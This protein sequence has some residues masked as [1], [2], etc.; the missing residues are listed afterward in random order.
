MSG[1]IPL[2]VDSDGDDSD[3][4]D[5]GPRG[6]ERGKEGRALPICMILVVMKEISAAMVA[7]QKQT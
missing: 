5:F 3:E 7:H 1:H 4:G 6:R 2:D